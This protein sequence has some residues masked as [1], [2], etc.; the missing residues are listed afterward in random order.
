[1][2]GVKEQESELPLIRKKTPQYYNKTVK[3]RSFS[4]GDW[5]LRKVTLVAKDPAK[6]KLGQVWEGPFRVIKSNPKGAYHLEDTERRK[7]PRPWNA[8][9]LQKYYV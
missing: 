1:M 6:G 3:P 9:H 2:K 5:V 7:L 8:K 4:P